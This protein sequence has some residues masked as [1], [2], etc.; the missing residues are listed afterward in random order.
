MRMHDF[1]GAC[2]QGYI[3]CTHQEVAV[4]MEGRSS[5]RGHAALN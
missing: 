2:V 5:R 4:V 3:E 1:R